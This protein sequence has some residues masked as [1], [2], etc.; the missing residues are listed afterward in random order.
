MNR[1]YLSP[2]HLTGKEQTYL[3]EVLAS[4]WITS[5]GKMLDE[6]EAML[7]AYTGASFALATNSGTSAI[8]LG[9]KLLGVGEGDYV[10]CPTLTFIA[11][12]NPILYLGAKPIFVDVDAWGNVAPEALAE[13]LAYCAREGRK[14]R[15]IIVVHLFG[16]SAQM[17]ELI[18]I[19]DAY[20]IPILEDAAEALGGTYAGKA[21]GTWGRVGVLSFNGNKI[22]TTSGGGALLLPT[23]EMREKA[24][25]WATQAKD[26]APHYQHSEMGYNYRLSNVLAGVG[27]A[28][29]EVLPVRVA[30]KREIFEKWRIFF[31]K[32]PTV[33]FL[34]PLPLPAR[35]PSPPVP[36][37][38]LQP[39]NPSTLLPPYPSTSNYWLTVA[40][41]EHYE[42]REKVRLSLE[43]ANIE[44]RPVWKPLH[45]QPVFAQDIYIG[46]RVAE[47]IF[48]RGLCLP[49]GTAM[50]DEEMQY[51]FKNVF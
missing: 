5:A 6:F 35:S 1:I 10:I 2:P 4:N 29:M 41:F 32:Y 36:L 33:S 40:L 3:Q 50:T 28:Q 14:V 37:F 46:G 42:M 16:H 15:A 21:L 34:N 39:F 24:L 45:L 8:H 26:Q 43:K 47:G 25:F 22:I 17:H 27:K 12:A 38:S 48:Q 11:T 9:L 51:C 19:A 7:C 31:Q 18:T 49:S 13:A 30:Q 44:S 20:N 23:A